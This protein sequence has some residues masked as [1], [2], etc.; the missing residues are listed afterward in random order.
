[1]ESDDWIH[2][3]VTYLES[4]RQLQL[5]VIIEEEDLFTQKNP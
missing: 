3:Y 4:V 1:M 2:I 5:T